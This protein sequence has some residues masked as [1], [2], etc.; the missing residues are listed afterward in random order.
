MERNHEERLFRKLVPIFYSGHAV[1]KQILGTCGRGLA[2]AFD[3]TAEETYMWHCWRRAAAILAASSLAEV[4]TLT[5][6][7]PDS[8]VY[9][10]T[11]NSGT[12][13]SSIRRLSVASRPSR[14][15]LI[16]VVNYCAFCSSYVYQVAPFTLSGVCGV[17]SCI[18]TYKYSV[19]LQR[20]NSPR[21]LY[22]EA[23]YDGFFARPARKI[24]Y[25]T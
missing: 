25:S 13:L 19:K 18:S 2:T 11:N 7:K 15:S 17:R 12:V 6:H 14:V 20:C 3:L 9:H 4:K 24:H 23:R 1:G 22:L 5:R 16:A 10:Y 8:A 21:G